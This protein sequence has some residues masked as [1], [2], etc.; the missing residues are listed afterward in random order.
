MKRILFNVA[1]FSLFIFGIIFGDYLI[2][3]IGKLNYYNYQDSIVELNA[4]KSE[5]KVLKK[6]LDNIKKAN[7]IDNYLEYDYLKSELLLR[8]IYN[9]HNTITIRYGYDKNIKKGM[10]VVSEH[11]LIGIIEKV[12]KHSSIVKL[13]TSSANSISVA[14]DEDYGVLND[15]DV[16][17]NYLVASNFNNYEVIMKNDE[18][19]TSGLGLIPEGL[20]I[21]KV[22]KTINTTNNIEQKV[23]IKSDNNFNNIKY[24]AIIRGIKE[25]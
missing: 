16:N 25:L 19:Y 12:G 11:G 7:N 21:G 3:G 5:N 20:Y 22:V 8:D 17:N 1:V 9:F 10:A 18:V 13:I 6:E 2:Y 4:L 24:V 14:I 15:Y 23:F